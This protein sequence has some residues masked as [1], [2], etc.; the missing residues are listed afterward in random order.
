MNGPTKVKTAAK[1]AAK[2]APPSAQ[3][4]QAAPAVKIAVKS[5]RSGSVAVALR[6]PEPISRGLPSG[7]RV[8]PRSPVRKPMIEA[9]ARMLEPASMPKS[10]VRS[11]ENK[12]S[13]PRRSPRS[14]KKELFPIF[15]SWPKR[16]TKADI[17]NVSKHFGNLSEGCID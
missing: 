10:P 14:A 11:V 2:N 1:V 7:E 3:K 8:E 6:H 4:K 5:T 9:P 12:T 15:T 17:E 16:P 13:E